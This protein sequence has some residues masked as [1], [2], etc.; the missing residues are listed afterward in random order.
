MVSEENSYQMMIVWMEFTFEIE[1]KVSLMVEILDVFKRHSN[2]WIVHR[3]DFYGLK[4]VS[5]LMLIVA[6]LN[7]S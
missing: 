7:F 2:S 6:S 4:F 3:I 5:Q 1:I